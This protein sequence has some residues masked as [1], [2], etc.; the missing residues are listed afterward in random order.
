VWH[1]GDLQKIVKRRETNVVNE[2]HTDANGI[3]W[4]TSRLSKEKHGFQPFDQQGWQKRYRS[5]MVCGP[6]SGRM[7]VWHEGDVQGV[8][9]ERSVTVSNARS[10]EQSVAPANASAGTVVNSIMLHA[11]KTDTQSV[12]GRT[13]KSQFSRRRAYERDHL[14]SQWNTQEQ[15]TPATIRDRWN[16]LTD[17]ERR[18]VSPRAW[19]RIESEAGKEGSR[20]VVKKAIQL[21][22]RES[23]QT[24]E[25]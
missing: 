1:A 3:R 8:A 4:I 9:A 5:K 22:K 15:M 24:G 12:A 18:D 14:W 19:K 2:I 21:A 17:E 16:Q 13:T 11:D 20:D 6:R 23:T 25:N 10:V 7:R